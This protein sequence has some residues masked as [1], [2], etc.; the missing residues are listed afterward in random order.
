MLAFEATT[1]GSSI[2]D[3]L[4]GDIVGSCCN[5]GGGGGGVR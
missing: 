5:G 4:E 1:S 2:L 3:V